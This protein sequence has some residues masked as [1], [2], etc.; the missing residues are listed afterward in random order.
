MCH[1]GLDDWAVAVAGVAR[2]ATADRMTSGALIS[3]G[4]T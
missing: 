3:G 2:V 4:T 1:G